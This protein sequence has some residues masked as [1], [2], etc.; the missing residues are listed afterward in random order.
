MFDIILFITSHMSKAP[1]IC[2]CRFCHMKYLP[3]L[4][5]YTFV[6]K[7][8]IIAAS[9]NGANCPAAAADTSCAAAP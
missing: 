8:G 5:N 2:V 1:F 9:G 7:M 4:G 6:A 3:E